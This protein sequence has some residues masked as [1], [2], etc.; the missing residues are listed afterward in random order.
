[1][2]SSEPCPS[3]GDFTPPISTTVRKTFPL[4]TAQRRAKSIESLVELDRVG[5]K[6]RVLLVVEQGREVGGLERDLAEVV[7]AAP[8][9]EGARVQALVE[10]PRPAK[11]SRERA[12]DEL[13]E[14]PP[15]RR[16]MA[17]D[18]G[19]VDVGRD[20]DEVLHAAL[21]ELAA[22]RVPLDREARPALLGRPVDARVR[23]G[24][25]PRRAPG[26][27]REWHTRDDHLPGSG[28]RE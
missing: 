4:L 15:W 8:G 19:V 2:S 6:H 16:V 5:V 26:R 27:D 21:A 1:L 24:V 11:S 20:E 18:L 25:T 14:R 12:R 13:V 22:E 3:V 28:R 10:R 9:E 17:D 23:P 7:D